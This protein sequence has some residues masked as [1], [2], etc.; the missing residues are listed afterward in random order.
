MKPAPT[1]FLTAS[2]TSQANLARRSAFEDKDY[3]A[4]LKNFE[5]AVSL[6]PQNPY[7]NH[8]L[9]K[10]YMQTGAYDQAEIYL[11]KAWQIDPKIPDLKYDLAW[12]HFKTEQYSES[13]RI[14][15]EIAE[16]NPLNVLATYYAGIS[17][18]KLKKYDQAL[19]YFQK[20]SE[21]SPTV[22]AN[23]YY[24]SGL[25]FMKTGKY[26]EAIK[27]FQYVRENA[28]SP[29]LKQNAEKWLEAGEDQIRVMKRWSFYGKLG[30]QW[31]SNVLLEPLDE[32]LPTGE[33]DSALVI[34]LDGRY[35]FINQDQ[36]KI[37]AGY[38]HYQT[39]YDDLTAYDLMGSMPQ[40]FLKYRKGEVL[41]G[42][43]Y[44]PSY[45][46]VDEKKY[47]LSQRFQPSLMWRINKKFSTRFTYAYDTKRYYL[48]KLRDG[49]A[50]LGNLD[51]FYTLQ[52]GKSQWFA[53]VGHERNTTKVSDFSW[54]AMRARIGFSLLLPW[55]LKNVVSFNFSR[56]EYRDINPTFGFKRKDYRYD[57]YVS[58]SRWLLYEWLNIIVEYKYT[59][60]D[61]NVLNNQ[62]IQIFD[63]EKNVATLSLSVNF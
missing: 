27:K 30:Y 46:W 50:S 24:Y 16:E 18:F 11:N 37:G 4:A 47:L 41:L 39:S 54:D 31:D 20:S 51:F 63:Y 61:S 62:N 7:Y 35:N 3:G 14:F 28:V 53:G 60:N 1:L 32:D 8:F 13:A 40:I 12:L 38:T 10:T 29:V 6:S 26:D 15:S 34:F 17:L 58:M 43:N 57:A 48:N 23:G 44:N 25:C 49:H 19:S 59:R 9:A 2:I 33:E 21:M 36:L 42:F 52:E 55:D 22:K 5:M 56:K 45:F